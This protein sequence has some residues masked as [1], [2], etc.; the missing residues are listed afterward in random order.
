MGLL[1]D[2]T[3]VSVEDNRYGQC[4]VSDWTD[5]ISVS[6]GEPYTVGLRSDGTVVTTGVYNSGSTAPDTSGWTDITAIDAGSY[7]LI[8]L[9]SDGTVIVTEP[10]Q[11]GK[12]QRNG[13]GLEWRLLTDQQTFGS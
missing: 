5:I 9:K 12:Y 1:V 11:G 3:A 6:R 7:Q 10:S 4:N 2:G 8:G 13:C